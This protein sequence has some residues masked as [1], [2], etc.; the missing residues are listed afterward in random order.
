MTAILQQQ[1]RGLPLITLP[2]ASFNKSFGG[3]PAPNAVKTLTVR[4][5]I[6]GKPGEAT[7]PENTVI[8][9]PAPK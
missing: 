8:L 6:D 3:D 4:Y 1:V 5:R 2:A 7:F 9:L